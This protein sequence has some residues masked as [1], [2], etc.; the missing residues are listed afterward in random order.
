[1]EAFLKNIEVAFRRAL[2]RFLRPL[3]RRRRKT[4]VAVDF[5]RC[6]FLFIRQDRIGDVLISSPLFAALKMRHPDA[7]IDVLLSSNNHFVLA[8][9][10]LIR[11]RWIYEKTISSAWKILRGL[12]AERYDFVIDLMDNPSATSTVICLLSRARWTVGLEKENSYAYDI[13]VPLMSRRDTHIVDRIARLLHPFGIEPEKENL[14]IRYFVSQESM[15]RARSILDNYGISGAP[16]IGINIS[17]GDEV[18]FWGVDNFRTLIGSIQSKVGDYRILVLFKPTHES[19]ARSIAKDLSGVF[20][21]PVTQSFDEFA[22]LIKHLHV[23]ITPD[24][25]AAHIAAAFQIPA[26]VMYVQ[27]NKDLRI[28]EPYGSPHEVLVAD[29]DDLTVISPRAVFESVERLLRRTKN[30][31]T[32][33]AAVVGR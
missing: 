17:A 7:A 19:T 21:S 1:M 27:S 30:Q 33:T 20:L 3:V 28:W 2:I 10:P 13:V 12:W 4:P 11:K 26:V 31:D 18:R 29:V 15:D 14:R 16:I 22:A 32:T 24:T 8:N 6:K 5:N 25:S 23:L 9:D